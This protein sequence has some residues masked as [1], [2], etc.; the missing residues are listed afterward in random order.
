MTGRF[1][2]SS[3][4]RRMHRRGPTVTFLTMGELPRRLPFVCT[5]GPSESFPSWVD[6]TAAELGT[7]SGVLADAIGLPMRRHRADCVPRMYGVTLSAASALAVST[8]T[9]LTPEALH[10]MHL[11]HL[12]GGPLKLT[13]LNPAVD[14]T[15]TS[16]SRREWFLAHGSRAC[17]GCLR[18]TGGQWKLEWKLRLVAVCDQ[19]GCV[20][21]DACPQCQRPLRRSRRGAAGILRRDVHALPSHCQGTAAEPCGTDLTTTVTVPAPA[22]ALAAQR[23][24]R[25]VINSGHG[26]L[27]NA[28]LETR[29]Y[30][31][32]IRGLAAAVRFAADP[33]LLSADVPAA[34]HD[35]YLSYI[36]RT[37]GLAG[38]AHGYQEAPATAAAMTAVLTILAAALTA[39]NAGD[40]DAVLRPLADSV[41]ARRRQRRHNPLRGLPLPDVLR[42][43]PVPFSGRVAGVAPV[44]VNVAIRHL[45]QLLDTT[46]YAQLEPLL[47][48]L[49]PRDGRRYGALL[50]ARALGARNWVEA[51]SWTGWTARQA[52]AIAERGSA[53]V[54]DPKLLWSTVEDIARSLQGTNVDWHLRRTVHASL[55]AVEPRDL[56]PAA[57]L[58][59]PWTT[60]RRRCAAAWLWAACT[61]GDWRVSPAMTD[62]A[63]PATSPSRRELYRRFTTRL[64]DDLADALRA[65]CVYEKAT[66]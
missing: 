28:T 13:G 1:S 48:K 39:D 4:W 44:H 21:M 29:D 35:P 42:A 63:W 17:P 60:T 11:S 8:A 62:P 9:G 10:A 6:R 19:H 31:A 30:I 66:A 33:L 46:S 32:T 18:E 16:V 37:P 41:S 50:A 54:A 34:V 38:G 45:P 57:H 58:G 12:D 3:R 40:F 43:Q 51:G 20:L 64:T 25:S 56:G 65:S 2:C 61:C 24:L 36:A 52:R 47:G 14:R 59:A 53:A 26:Q 5:P 49:R 23:V 55:L 22:A 7:P 15:V 27:G